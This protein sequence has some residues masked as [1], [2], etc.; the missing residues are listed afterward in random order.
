M[1]VFYD[2]EVDALYIRFNDLKP[3][4]VV[5]VEEGVNLDV[6]KDGKIVGIEI[7]NASEKVGVDTVFNYSLI[8]KDYE[9]AD[10]G[11]KE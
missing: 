11:G 10:V 6:T 2:S 1:K 8:L 9:T 3:E 7:L 5:E 4:G